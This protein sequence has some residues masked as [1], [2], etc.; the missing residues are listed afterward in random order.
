[1]AGDF[2]PE[3]HALLL[4]SQGKIYR[5]QQSVYQEGI[6]GNVVW[7]NPETLNTFLPAPP[8]HREIEVHLVDLAIQPVTNQVCVLDNLNRVWNVDTQEMILQG[9][10][11]INLVRSLHFASNQ[12]P[13]TIDVNNRLSYNSQKLEFPFKGN[14]FSHRAGFQADS[15]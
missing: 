14:W 15:G 11:S 4:S 2:T 6:E 5:V 7:T 13:L 10:P 9:E 1:M 3:G 8:K 12:E